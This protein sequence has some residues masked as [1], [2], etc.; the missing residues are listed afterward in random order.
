MLHGH[1]QIFKIVPRK[2][3]LA[4]A[5][6]IGVLRP[7]SKGAEI[8]RSWESMRLARYQQEVDRRLSRG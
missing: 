5:T 1:A 3:C 6:E 4:P 8:T 7:N 2:K